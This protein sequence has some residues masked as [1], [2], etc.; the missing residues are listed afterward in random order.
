MTFLGN[1]CILGY[2]LRTI[3]G[4]R[5]IFKFQ[6]VCELAHDF[7][8]IFTIIICRMYN[9]LIRVKLHRIF[10]KIVQI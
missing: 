9:P 4:D 2:L 1:E 7:R 3:N 8:T 5:M 6:D 10:T